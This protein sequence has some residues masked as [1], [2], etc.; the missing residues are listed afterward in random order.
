MHYDEAN[1]ELWNHLQQHS[2]FLGGTQTLRTLQNV[3]E[4]WVLSTGAFP[5]ET[6]ENQVWECAF[7]KPQ[8]IFLNI[9]I[10]D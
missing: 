6:S 7:N 3:Q 10:W 1:E 9:K 2:T 8:M 5:E 4:P